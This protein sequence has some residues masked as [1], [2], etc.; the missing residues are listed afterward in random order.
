MKIKTIEA[1]PKGF[2][3][4]FLC[5]LARGFLFRGTARFYIVD[6]MGKAYNL[7]RFGAYDYR[8]L[9]FLQFPEEPDIPAE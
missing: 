5:L 4:E 6:K 8:V 1:K 3:Q 9:L 2:I 7:S